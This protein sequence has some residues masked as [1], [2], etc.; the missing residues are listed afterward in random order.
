MHLLYLDHSGDMRDVSQKHFVLAGISGF[1]R[2]TYWLS[3]E[4]DKIAA[5]LNAADPN[6]VE[7]HESPMRGGREFWR[8]FKVPDR[9]QALKDVLHVAIDRNS[10]ISL[11]GAVV[12]K[13]AVLPDDTVGV[14]FEKI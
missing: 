6:S 7:I 10:G 2:Q 12:E 4:I 13:N 3:Q 11:F 9:I 5:S 1:E 8:K 14:S